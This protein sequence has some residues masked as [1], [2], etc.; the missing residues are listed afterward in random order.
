M[1]RLHDGAPGGEGVGGRARGGGH[2]EPV[3]RVRGEARAVEVDVD[4]HG[5][6]ARGLLE[7]DLVERHHVGAP[8][9]PRGL[10]VDGQHHAPLEGVAVAEE[11][12]QRGA[13]PVGLDVGEV[14]ELAEV[15]SD[16]GDLGL[17]HQR[18]RAQHGAV[19]AQAHH[20]VEA[21]AEPVLGDRQLGATRPLGVRRRD[22][23]L[24]AQVEQPRRGLGRHLGRLEPV[25]VDHQRHGRHVRHRRPHGPRPRPAR[26]RRRAR[27]RRGG[28]GPRRGPSLPGR[29]RPARTPRCRRSR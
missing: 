19:A 12:L 24:V 10:D 25:V 4:A 13:E 28:R 1:G 11:R 26:A 22:A 9:R 3:G 21:V 5:V 23:H 16:D 2:D 17:G 15:H 6:A 20:H 14:A 8:E 27:R 7:D 29:A 18:H